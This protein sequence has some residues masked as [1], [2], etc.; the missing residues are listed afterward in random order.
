MSSEQEQN[1]QP[2]AET[3]KSKIKTREQIDRAANPAPPRQLT[4]S[5]IMVYIG[6]VV[7]LYIY[8]A[9]FPGFPPLELGANLATSVFV[10]LLVIFL[11]MN[12][13]PVGWII[14]TLLES[15]YIVIFALQIAS[16]G[17]DSAAKLWGLLFLSIAALALLLTRTTRQFVWAPDPEIIAQSTGDPD[18]PTEED[19][20]SDQAGSPSSSSSRSSSI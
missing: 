12:R 17:G 2:Q 20:R 10:R 13:S 4:P 18:A 19:Q 15:L 5:S 11:L 14:G 8:W 9:L 3:P 1:E 7:F 6:L 16:L